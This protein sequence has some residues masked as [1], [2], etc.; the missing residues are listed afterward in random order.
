[1]KVMI[2]DDNAEVR[3]LIRT[4]LADL[5]GEFVECADGEQ[6]VAAYDQHRPDW[7]VMD[8]M[9]DRM[10]GL[11]ATQLITSRFPNSHIIII[12][13]HDNPKLRARASEVGATRF[14]IKDN[15]LE[16]R[17]SVMQPIS[18]VSPAKA[19]TTTEN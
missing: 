17:P 3:K 2:V 5:A 15:L 12:T 9:M 16:L 4:V 8:V 13:Q 19:T 6:A 18:D 10:D 11:T 7:T 14:L 1:M